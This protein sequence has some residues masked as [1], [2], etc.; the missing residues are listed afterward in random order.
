MSASIKSNDWQTVAVATVGAAVGGGASLT[1]FQF[2]SKKSDFLGEY[3]FVGGG[4]GLGGSLNSAVAP[5]PSDFVNRGRDLNYWCDLKVSKPFSGDDLSNSS[6][7]ITSAGVSAAY[8]YSIVFITA[9]IFDKLFSHQYI[10]GWG[11]GVGVSAST[12]KGI[13]VRLSTKNYY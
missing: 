4:I 2:R 11:I 8:G 10:G 9:G 1:M 7:D 12:M 13:W 6:G 5:S 3:L